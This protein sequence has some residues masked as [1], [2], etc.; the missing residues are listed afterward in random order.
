MRNHITELIRD[1]TG[2]RSITFEHSLQSLWSGYGSIDRYLLSDYEAQSV[3]VKHVRLPLHSEHPRGWHG[4]N[5]HQ[6]KL[7]SYQVETNWYRNH[8]ALCDNNCRVP[9]VIAIEQQGDEIIMLMEDLD[10]SGYALRK[11]K[12]NWQDIEACLYWLAAFHAHFMGHQ[13]EGLWPVGSYWHLDTRPDE[14]A[15]MPDGPLK[16][17][18]ATIDKKLTSAAC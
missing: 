5:S 2:A 10:R 13:P 12:V 9:A 3:I 4:E 17:K 8:A 15:A 7:R 6:R 14:L 18:A 16:K 1:K 11:T